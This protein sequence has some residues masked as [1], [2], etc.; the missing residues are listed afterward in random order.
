MHSLDLTF[1]LKTCQLRVKWIL[2]MQNNPICTC[3]KPT[4]EFSRCGKAKCVVGGQEQL[5]FAS[6]LWSVSPR[7]PGSNI[8][9]A[10]LKRLTASPATCAQFSQR[11]LSVIDNTLVNYV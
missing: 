7:I 5:F 10:G 8:N 2:N 9:G 6:K 4:W 1:A 11:S 3:F